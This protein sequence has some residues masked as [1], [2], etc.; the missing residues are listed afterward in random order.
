MARWFATLLVIALA[1]AQVTAR[2]VPSDAGLD[3]Q[4][5]VVTFGGLG[6]YSGIGSNEVQIGGTSIGGNADLGVGGIA[7]AHVDLGSGGKNG[8][9]NIGG[10]GR[11]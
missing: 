2:T 11:P 3:D 5:N 10:N 7:K 8:G 9:P 6:G 1:V 4:K